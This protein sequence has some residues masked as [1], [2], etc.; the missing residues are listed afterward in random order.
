MGWPLRKCASKSP[1]ESLTLESFLSLCAASAANALSLSV[2]RK[3]FLEDDTDGDEPPLLPEVGATLRSALLP[4]RPVMYRAGYYK[5]CAFLKLVNYQFS[6]KYGGIVHCSKSSLI[7]YF[8]PC[9][10]SAR[11]I[12]HTSQQSYLPWPASSSSMEYPPTNGQKR[13]R[14][15]SESF[16][17][18]VVIVLKVEVAE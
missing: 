4:E 13:S 15:K 12:C 10:L 14:Q 7:W 9:P 5:G 6:V 1:C 8:R 18:F 3:N 2:E 11:S 16:H 17:C